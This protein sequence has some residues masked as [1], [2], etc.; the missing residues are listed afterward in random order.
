MLRENDSVF[1]QKKDRDDTEG[2]KLN[3]GIDR[4]KV[5]DSHVEI[6]HFARTLVP[7]PMCYGHEWLADD[8]DAVASVAMALGAIPSGALMADQA[9]QWVHHRTAFCVYRR[10][11]YPVVCA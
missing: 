3:V 1:R 2:D 10:R 7:P 4:R 6:S 5:I 11:M 8:D 9:F